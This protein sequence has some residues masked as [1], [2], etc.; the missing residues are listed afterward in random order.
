[1]G[2]P[3]LIKSLQPEASQGFTQIPGGA[4]SDLGI[5]V[6]ILKS[7][8]SAKTIAPFVL[9]F[10]SLG[11]GLYRQRKAG[12]AQWSGLGWE[13][14]VTLRWFLDLIILGILSL[15]AVSASPPPWRMRGN[16]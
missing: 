4:L 13:V 16:G 7:T 12:N 8:K 3:R 9:A 5:H 14:N 10:I 11:E 1:M 2:R 6:K 15:S